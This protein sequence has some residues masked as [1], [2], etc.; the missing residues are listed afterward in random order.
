MKQQSGNIVPSVTY[1]ETATVNG[2][3]AKKVVQI[4]QFGQLVTCGDLTTRIVTGSGNTY[5]AV[6]YPGTSTSA[7]LWQVQKID[8]SGNI[9]WADGNANFDNQATDLSS[10][11]YS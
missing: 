10:L 3:A 5:V 2:V 4:D 8:S 7:E 6:A 11:E 1:D 9:T